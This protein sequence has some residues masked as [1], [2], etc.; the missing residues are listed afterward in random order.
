[1]YRRTIT[2]LV[3]L[4]V[5]L[6]LLAYIFAVAVAVQPTPLG[7]SL[8][9]LS[10]AGSVISGI[11]GPIIGGITVLF[12][13]LGFLHQTE[14]IRDVANIRRKE[15]LLTII[16]ELDERLTHLLGT[17]LPNY[18]T[19]LEELIDE[20]SIHQERY[21]Q[22]VSAYSKGEAFEQLIFRRAWQL[23]FT[24]HRYLSEF[25]LYELQDEDKKEH[26]ISVTTRYYASR[27]DQL[28]DFLYHCNPDITAVFAFIR[29]QAEIPNAEVLSVM[30]QAT[31]LDYQYRQKRTL[32]TDTQ[33]TPS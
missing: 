16:R 1:M 3:G 15:N 21:D 25:Y 20:Q 10:A 5:F 7:L 11:T 23:Y 18:R 30:K 31:D 12:I 13:Y 24:F 27:L 8:D 33:S 29:S 17:R 19:T 32:A 6:T 4:F 28:T 9:N 2:W 26:G 14:K 22:F